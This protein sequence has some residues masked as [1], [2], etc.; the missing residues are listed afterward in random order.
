[1]IMRKQR[2]GLG[3][4]KTEGEPVQV[5]DMKRRVKRLLAEQ[6]FVPAICSFVSLRC[7]WVPR[8]PDMILLLKKARGIHSNSVAAVFPFVYSHIHDKGGFRIG[9]SAGLPVF[10]DF[11]VRDRNRVNSNM[12]VIGKSGGGKSFATKMMLTNLA[13][14]NSKIL[15]WIR[16]MSIRLWPRAFTAT[17][18]TWEAPHRAASIPSTLSRP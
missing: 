16:K 8:Y 14:E 5:S 1:M 18:L 3:K 9:H 4:N 7:S 15:F 17:G 2:G 13:A 12:V 11:F 10:I 6:S